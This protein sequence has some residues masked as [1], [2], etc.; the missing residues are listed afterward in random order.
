[1]N[2]PL[3]NIRRQQTIAEKI[4]A[5]PTAYIGPIAPVKELQWIVDENNNLQMVQKEIVYVP[6]LYKIFDEILMNAVANKHT[7]EIRIDID[8]SINEI[9]IWNN[10]H[11]IPILFNKTEQKWLPTMIFGNF[12]Q[13]KIGGAKLCN[14]FCT[15]FE[16]EIASAGKLFTQSWQGNMQHEN[17]EE[18]TDTNSLDYTKITFNPDLT[19]LNMEE[20][21][22]DIV[23]LL[24]RRAFDVGFVISFLF[25]LFS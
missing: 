25:N 10:G 16:I 22:D 18:I 9:S 5:N 17:D 20:M 7:S 19:K 8:S 2:R 12:N 15:N 1:M 6:G 13:P 11:G 23:G 4:C 3:R 21:N 14:M 24:K